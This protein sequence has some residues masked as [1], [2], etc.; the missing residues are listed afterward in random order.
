M[1]LL[2]WLAIIGS[3][4]CCS[5]AGP[6]T[7]TEISR[8]REEAA[9]LRGLTDV[10]K[11]E[12]GGLLEQAAQLVQQEIRWRAQSVGHTRSKAMLQNELASARAAALLSLP[13]APPA[14]A[15]ETAQQVDEELARVRNERSSQLRRI[16]EFTKLQATLS[17]RDDGI[18][19]R[20]A[21]IRESLRSIEDE[22][23]VLSLALASPQWE[24]AS[25]MAL[26]ARLQSMEQEFQAL[27]LEREVID[28]RRQLI[29]MQRE[30]YLL[31]LE[32]SQQY[33]ADLQ[34]RKVNARTRDA[35]KSL[36]DSIAQA[37][38]LSS[39]F[40]QLALLSADIEQNSAQLWGPDGV[41]ARTER[42][43]AHRDE[44]R[45]SLA[46]YKEIAADTQRRYQNSGMLS[47]AS[48]WWPPRVEKFGKP[49]E[50]G[51]LVLAY[52]AAEVVARRDLFRLEEELRKA[53][54]FEVQL[55]GLIAESGKQ[56]EDQDYD[57]FRNSSR[58]L[59][60]LKRTVM[61][62]LL[63][64]QR[65]LV[66]VVTE[67]HGVAEE[68][69][70]TIGGLQSFVL[71]RVLWVRSVSGP[72]LPSLA[73]T[74]DGFLW[75]FDAKKWGQIANGFR[76]QHTGMLVWALGLLAAAVLILLRRRFAAR[77]EVMLQRVPKTSGV[78][79]LVARIAV[80]LLAALPAPLAIAYVGWMIGQAGSD[81]DLG[82]AIAA[83]AS[84][85]GKLLYLALLM[86]SMLADTGAADRLLGWPPEV[87]KSIDGKLRLLI[88][89]AGPLSF[90][91][92]ALA[93]EGMFF[94]GDSV[95]QSHHNSFGRL[96]F[97]A[98]ALSVVVIGRRLLRPSGAVATALGTGFNRHGF[99]RPRVARILLR[100]VFVAAFTLA[101]LG[102]YITAYLLVANAMKTAAWTLLLML[103]SAVLNEWRRDRG[104]ANAA[105]R[106]VQGA[107]QARKSEQ[108]VRQ[109]SRFG[110]TLVWIGGGLVI[111]SAALPALSLLKR[112]ELLPEVRVTA[113]SSSV[114]AVQP[115]AQEPAAPP[116][117]ATHQATAPEKREQEPV[118]APRQPL[119]LSHVLLAIFVAVLTGMF[120]KNIPGLLHFTVFRR[121]SFDVGG[122]YAITTIARYLAIVFG[123]LMV[124]TILG[125]N[126]SKIQWLA[127]ALTFGI[128]FGL[129]EIFANFAA[130][131]ILLLDRSIRVGDAVTV[132]NL[133]G[134]VSRIQ[135]RAT[136]VTLWDLSDMV[137]PN[138]EFITTKLVNWTLSNPE[139]RVDL[140]V[141]IDYGSDVEQVREVLLRLAAEHPAVLK[142]PAPQ[143]LLT[144][145]AESAIHFE[146]RVFGLYSYGRPVLL[147]ELHRALVRE[148]RRL[149]IVIAFP[150]LDVHLRPGTPAESEM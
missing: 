13:A 27:G 138:K 31:R 125:V 22:I 35:K 3:L 97:M 78:M 28:L 88:M 121:L 40:A 91:V 149:G 139:T 58:S 115:A 23:S 129:Q 45:S 133:S 92:A 33:M 38:S 21:E 64:S 72:I 130:G 34:I 146:L 106:T 9:R 16:D 90:F 52:S 148:F 50:V 132:G 94:H 131:L 144:E 68:L 140:K 109:L 89:F 44:M 53:S 123:L 14:P 67:A 15:S 41:E 57:K 26:Q 19:S 86:R 116:Q 43:A 30:S 112:V 101:L 12:L 87:R 79:P 98:V 81:V 104:E 66:N 10:E 111:W 60:Q 32:S 85:L 65:I 150:Q 1:K 47:P 128:G 117:P 8:A 2:A 120:V 110:L 71:Q 7:M 49:A 73:A 102:F 56:T 29:P 82:R 11:N 48:E 20:R 100:L 96:C 147:D 108:Q 6:V 127:A 62:E 74:A 126:W 37:K 99:S 122:L 143:V 105:A 77:L 114:R 42:A 135:M 84:T 39:G 124:S 113:E 142:D 119:Y 59:L 46:R 54:A 134:I 103:I 95:L 51:V 145:F 24:K 93:E 61:G 107:E 18:T 137:V 75:F 118:A 63:V 70:G 80:A 141:G 69:L 17:Q 55:K 4:C 36:E 5:A 76:S 25:R 136:T 83:G